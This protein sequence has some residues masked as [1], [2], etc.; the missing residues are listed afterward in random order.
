VYTIW[1]Q[2]PWGVGGNGREGVMSSEKRLA[3]I[4]GSLYLVV[5][6]LGG[7]AEL[8]VRDGIVKFGNPAATAE[9][10]S[11]S[12]TLFRMGFASDLVQATVFL[13]TAM[14]LY[15][16]LRHV[17]ELVARAMVVIVAVSVA[18][19]CLNLLN[20]HTALSLAT[21]EYAA[22]FG[23]TG[24]AALAGLF[25]DMHA[26]GYLIAQ[27]F[28][29]LWL[30]PLGYLVYRSGY[31]PKVLGVLLVLG[32]FGYLVDL[33]AHF[34]AP[35]VA[36]SIEVFLAVPGTVGELWLVAYLLVRGV[37]VPEQTSLLPVAA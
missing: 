31:F 37:R 36:G 1:K 35:G 34:L 27:M 16:L 5:A 17:N 10:I 12:A 7:F 11:G 6:V 33:F 4:A 20:Q 23:A 8:V 2:A 26:S 30:L 29:G 14:A 21:G 3:R 22:A 32:C 15:L 25:A 9:N 18:I 13:F 28:F 24:S 19:I